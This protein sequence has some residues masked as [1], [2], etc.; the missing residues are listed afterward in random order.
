M[1]IEAQQAGLIQ[2]FIKP[3][4]E[5]FRFDEGGSA[6]QPSRRAIRL[7]EA[8][9]LGVIVSVILACNGNYIG[10]YNLNNH[11]GVPSIL[12]RSFNFNGAQYSGCPYTYDTPIGTYKLVYNK[13]GSPQCSD[14][15]FP[16]GRTRF[17]LPPTPSRR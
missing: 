17:Y 11:N 13:D 9:A 1:P 12:N 5:G 14:P 10:T 7:G 2:H 15:E 8:V 3:N 16:D 6:K 4:W